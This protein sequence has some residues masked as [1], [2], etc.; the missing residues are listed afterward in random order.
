MT[1]AATRM[2]AIV[3]TAQTSSVAIALLEYPVRSRS[4]RLVSHAHLAPC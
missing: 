3:A 2:P 1:Q 4:R